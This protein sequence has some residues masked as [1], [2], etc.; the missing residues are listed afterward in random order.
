MRTPK[1]TLLIAAALLLASALPTIAEDPTSGVAEK[2][3]EQSGP[4][5][6]TKIDTCAAAEPAI[7]QRIMEQWNGIADNALESQ[8]YWRR[9]SGRG[10]GGVYGCAMSAQKMGLDTG[11]QRE[12]ADAPSSHTDT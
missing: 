1:P 3:P 10:C 4:P 5:T 12:N 7:R 8:L 9:Y 11:G 6:L 2:P